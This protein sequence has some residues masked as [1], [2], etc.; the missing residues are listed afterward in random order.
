MIPRIQPPPDS[1]IERETARK[2]ADRALE[3]YREYAA[4]NDVHWL[5]RADSFRHEAFEHAA[6]VGDY[7]ASVGDV[8]RELEAVANAA[9]FVRVLTEVGGLHMLGAA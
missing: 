9:G 7:G 2:W 4:T 3:A 5:V 8:Q 1:E 6:E